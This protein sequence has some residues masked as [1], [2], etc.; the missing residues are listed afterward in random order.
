MREGAETEDETG[1]RWD[2]CDP[3]LALLATAPV[4]DEPVTADDE[5]HIAEGRRAYRQGETVAA[6]SSSG[7]DVV[8]DVSRLPLRPQRT[9]TGS[10]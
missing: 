6:D 7:T 9:P 3:V 4:A 5:R 8:V 1:D 10:C 2:P